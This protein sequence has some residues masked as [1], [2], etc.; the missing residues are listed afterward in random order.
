VVG[1]QCKASR[2]RSEGVAASVRCDID[3][4][5]D[6]A[7][8]SRGTRAQEG[9]PDREPSRGREQVQVFERERDTC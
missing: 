7:G 1:G 3:L 5:D 2:W 8:N 6:A 9:A 4:D